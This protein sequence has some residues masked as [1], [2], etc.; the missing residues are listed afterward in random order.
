M[1][2]TRRVINFMS[3][4]VTCPTQG[5]RKAMAAAKV[6]DDVYGLDPTVKQLQKVMASMLG[7]EEAMF[8]PSGTMSNLIAIGTHCQRGDEVICGNKSHIFT[9]EGGAYMGVSLATLPNQPDG[10][11]KLSDMAHAVRADDMHY[12]RTSLVEIENTHNTC[13]GRVLPLSYI[14][15]V[16]QFCKDHNLSLHVDGARL[17]NASVASGVALED[18]VKG[19]DTVSFCLSKGLG[20]PVGSMLAGSEEFIHHAKRL[21][22][23]LGGGLRQSGIVAAG[24][25]YA[26]EHQF[27][28][29]AEDH[30]NAKTLAHGLSTIAGIEIDVDSVDTNMLFFKVSSD[31][32]IDTPTLVK[33]VAEEKGIIFGGYWRGD[34]IRAVTNLH[35][36]S[37][38]VK[39]TIASVRDIVA[40]SE[41]NFQVA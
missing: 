28:R 7:K 13:G 14:R 10:T 15:D 30:E 17:A 41:T 29:L 35:V 38:D 6:G 16:E 21:R 11:I 36:T 8:V 33:K 22:K 2:A 4:T 5:M 3:D 25:L 20:A 19:A 18:L 31:F 26:L 1:T 9:Y 34:E 23:S 32:K 40:A 37:D 12:P 27:D 39:Y 24:A